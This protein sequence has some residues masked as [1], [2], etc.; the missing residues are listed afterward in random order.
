MSVASRGASGEAASDRDRDHPLSGESR[1]GLKERLL[2]S[3]PIRV[4]KRYME[5]NAPNWATII[6]WNAL[7]AFFPIVLV[8]VT[9][10]GIVIHDPGVANT[11][12][13]KVATIFGGSPDEQHEILGAFRAF[14][15]QTGILGIVGFLTLLWSGTSLMS[16]LDQAINSLHWCKPRSFIKQK[17]MSIG[18]IAVFTVLTVPLVLSSSLLALLRDIPGLPDF[19][20]SGPATFLAQAALGVVD[21][22]LLFGVI[23]LIVPSRRQRLRGILPG[24]ILG[25]V[26]LEGYTLLFPLYF[27]LSHGF[28]TYGKTFALFFL[29]LT[30]VFVLGQMVMIGAAVNA[31]LEDSPAACDT[32]IQPPAGA[33]E[34][35]VAEK[36]E[37][38]KEAV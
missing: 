27:T 5:V 19:F 18:L 34:G 26:M 1:R 29:M 32:G 23:Y 21:G 28:T 22:A 6:A 16:A 9:I 20:Y 7:F 36:V 35:E 15:S 4:V 17:V 3:F 13:M 2:A 10:L 8:T 25:G 14:R 31:E 12:E 30:Y 11:V 24:A 37:A 38:A 33:P